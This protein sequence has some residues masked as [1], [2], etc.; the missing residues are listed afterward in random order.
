MKIGK[1]GSRSLK[2]SLAQIAKFEC[3]NSE[4]KSRHC[5]TKAW[6]NE[7]DLA[8]WFESEDVGHK[9]SVRR[10]RSCGGEE[11][12]GDIHVHNAD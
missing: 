10:A 4:D 2:S 7:V 5:H 9:Q 11:R 12:L 8:R 3:N 1:P 6:A